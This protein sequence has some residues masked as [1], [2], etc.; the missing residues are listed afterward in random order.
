MPAGRCIRR[1]SSSSCRQ[2]TGRSPA[3]SL[4]SSVRGVR[5]VRPMP[6]QIDRRTVQP[7]SKHECMRALSLR[8]S[9]RHLSTNDPVITSPI[10]SFSSVVT[11]RR[12]L[13]SRGIAVAFGTQILSTR[14]RGFL[15]TGVALKSFS[16]R[17]SSPS[18]HY[19]SSIIDMDVRSAYYVAL[20]FGITEVLV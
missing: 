5:R 17:G 16:R 1:R 3:Q 15:T 19:L 12:T 10:S 7:R 8:S 11:L 6:R 18:P 20:R 9:R 13:P 4:V 14:L 2:S